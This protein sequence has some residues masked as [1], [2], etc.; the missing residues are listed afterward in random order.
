MNIIRSHISGTQLGAAG[1]REGGRIGFIDRGPLV[2]W[3]PDVLSQM[4]TGL[5]QYMKSCL[6]VMIMASPPLKI[7]ARE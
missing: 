5:Q 7:R 2:S 3:L 4:Y 1:L 6:E